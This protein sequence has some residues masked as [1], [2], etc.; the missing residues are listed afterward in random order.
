ML[1]H[2]MDKL[3]IE[4][5]GRGHPRGELTKWTREHCDIINMSHKSQ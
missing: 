3:L 5:V 2:F 4:N 1:I